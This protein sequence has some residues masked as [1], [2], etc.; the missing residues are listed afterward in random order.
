LT[1]VSR[2]PSPPAVA[3]NTAKSAGAGTPVCVELVAVCEFLASR[4]DVHEGHAFGMSISP[5]T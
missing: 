5:R 4:H 2:D 3:S 1:T